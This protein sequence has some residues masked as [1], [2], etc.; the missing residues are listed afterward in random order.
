MIAGNVMSNSFIFDVTNGFTRYIAIKYDGSVI[1][2]D[3]M[4]LACV[5]KCNVVTNVVSM[6]LQS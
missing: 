1:N 6:C 3:S 5:I 4:G 2:S